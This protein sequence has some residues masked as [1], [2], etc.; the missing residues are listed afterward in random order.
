MFH[1]VVREQ[2]TERGARIRLLKTVMIITGKRRRLASPRRIANA[3]RAL[4]AQRERAWKIPR[5]K[6]A[7]MQK[8][9]GMTAT[10][11]NFLNVIWVVV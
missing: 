11:M 4:T 7:K 1:I 8:E 9:Y 10:L 2:L 6:S 5:K 3:E